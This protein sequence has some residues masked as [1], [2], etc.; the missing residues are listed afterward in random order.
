MDNPFNHIID[1]YFQK[2][3]ELTPSKRISLKKSNEGIHLS[4]N[5][6]YL[7]KLI[8][9]KKGFSSID[10]EIYF[11]KKVKSEPLSY[12]V[13][14][15]EV[16]S[17]ELLMPKIGLGNQLNFLE[18]KIK[19]INKF[20]NRN[21]DFVHY[22]EQ[23]LTYL[24]IQYFT[25]SNQVF[26]LYSLPETCYLDPKF[27]TSH[28]MLWSRIKGMNKFIL[29]LQEITKQLKLQK[30]KSLQIGKPKKALVWN[31][32]KTAL[33]ELIY[34]LHSANAISD[35]SGNVKAIA[36]V[37]ESVFN[38]NLDNLYKTYSEIKARKGGRSRFLEDLVTRFNEKM[39]KDD[40]F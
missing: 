9:E 23:E 11:F 8:V 38:V 26:P 34:A 7:L 27:F 31:A 36:T 33:T 16:R 10:E 19:R 14:F 32:S 1:G 4:N 25:R 6:L 5:A 40:S 30:H 29:Y 15:S 37:F 28:D 13:Y 24:D 17:C 18:K 21:R 12:L 20:F 39:E 3:E 22:M 2:L 35:G